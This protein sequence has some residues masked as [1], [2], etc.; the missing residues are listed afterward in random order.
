MS[1]NWTNIK[2]A[3]PEEINRCKKI[4]EHLAE[5]PTEAL[6]RT[7]LDREIKEAEKAL[8]SEDLAKI[9]KAYTKLQMRR[10]EVE[11]L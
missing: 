10:N 6:S 4:S 2:D 7:L 8:E 9:V 3:L 1:K 5:I 11:R